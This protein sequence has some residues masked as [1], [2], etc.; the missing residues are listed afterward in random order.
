MAAGQARLRLGLMA[1]LLVV[2]PFVSN[3]ASAQVPAP[4][5]SATVLA[6]ARHWLALLDSGHYAESL[7]SAAPLLRQMAGST[8]A[9]RQLVGRARAGFPASPGRTLVEVNFAPDLAGA[10]AGRYVRITFRVAAGSAM[11]N[12]VLALQA[13]GQGWRVAMYGTRPG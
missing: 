1:V 9:W 4:A 3:A 6:A 12:E 8:D 7:D 5:D 2:A 13:T 11:V 10:P